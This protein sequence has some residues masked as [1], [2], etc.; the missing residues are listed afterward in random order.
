VLEPMDPHC[1][2]LCPIVS[3]EFVIA[4]QRLGPKA[5]QVVFLGVN[6]NQYH[7]RPAEVDAFSRRHG[8]DRLPNWHFLTGSTAA[9]ERVWHAY[10]I[11]VEPSKSG[12]VVHSALMWFIDPQGRER[13]VAA[14]DYDKPQI[15]RFGAG[16]ASVT[17][18]LLS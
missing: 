3:Q 9:L 13:W 10:G 2:D 18:H 14:P 17:S 1:T 5:Q 8:L 16:I 6:V 15:P 4:A 12:D 11:S 7:E